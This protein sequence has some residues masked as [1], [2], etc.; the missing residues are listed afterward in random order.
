MDA[1]RGRHVGGGGEGLQS[2]R[3]SGLGRMALS[4]LVIAPAV[5]EP[6]LLALID[7]RRVVSEHTPDLENL[8]H[9]MRTM[10]AAYLLA[11][12]DGRP[13][14]RGMTAVFPGTE[15]DPFV[16]ADVSVLAEQRRRG[17]GEALLRAVSAQA[18]ALD[19]EVLQV[20]VREG[21]E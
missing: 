9:A 19:K 7:V 6:D 20:E 16:L 18:R 17:I 2:P 13:V 21:D 8:R 11:L 14:G 10:N 15:H 12:A 4:G 3:S 5:L 1:C